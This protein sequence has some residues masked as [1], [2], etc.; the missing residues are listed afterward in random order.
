MFLQ[1]CFIRKNTPEL[2]SKL[3]RLGYKYTPNGVEEWFIP[4]ESLDFICVNIY[5]SGKYI[6]ENG[7]W[8]H[9]WIDCGTNEQLF[10]AIASLR[11]DTDKNQ[12]FVNKSKNC[13]WKCSFN[14]FKEDFQETTE[15]EYWSYKHFHKATVE[16][17]I[18]F[19]KDK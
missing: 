6:G 13:W 11:D 5:S 8:N 18:E 1:P 4:I 7:Y 14:S 2:R 3:E 12:W 17:L 16:E 10:L 9:S 19:F 15:D